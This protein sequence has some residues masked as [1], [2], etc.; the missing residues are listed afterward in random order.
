[1]TTEAEF[2]IGTH[3]QR[4][5]QVHK[6]IEAV[7]HET[8]NSSKKISASYPEQKNTSSANKAI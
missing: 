5:L 4:V 6:F 3:I 2:Q 7:F 1:M 8:L